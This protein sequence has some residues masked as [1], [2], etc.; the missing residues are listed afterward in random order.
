MYGDVTYCTLMPGDFESMDAGVITPNCFF[1]ISSRL[2]SGK[3]LEN[4]VLAWPSII[5]CRTGE[6]Y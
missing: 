5:G 6:R 2:A 3:D 4:L 1:W